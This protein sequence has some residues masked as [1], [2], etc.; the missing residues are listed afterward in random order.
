MIKPGFLSKIELL[1]RVRALLRRVW[2]VI[3]VFLNLI[4]GYSQL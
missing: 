1:Y 4:T 2:N 3:S